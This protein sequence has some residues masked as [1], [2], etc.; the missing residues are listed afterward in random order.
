MRVLFGLI[1]SAALLVACDSTEGSFV[2]Y[3]VVEAIL[4]AGEPLPPVRLSRLGRFRD[5]YDDT[6]AALDGATVDVAL[7]R[8]DGTDEQV[9]RFAPQGVGRYAPPDPAPTVVPGRTYRLRVLVAAASGVGLDTLTARTTVPA[10]VELL[11]PPPAE[12]TYGEGNGPALRIARSST[13]ARRSVYLLASESLAPDEFEPVEIDGERRFR[14]RGLAGRFGL[15]PFL[16]TVL[17]CEGASGALVC[18]VDPGG[19]A[20]GRTPLL[21]EDNYEILPDGSARVSV[22]YVT[23]GFF[24]PQEVTVYSLDDA[25]VAYVETQTLQ[26]A[27]TTISPGEI[28]NVTTNVENGLGV[29]GSLAR[30]VGQTFLREP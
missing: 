25:L 24:G 26:F 23:F 20:T 29:F 17:G 5:V 3:P 4:E 27:P 19:A 13:E 12:V 10:H 28:P 6:T 2:P 18:D 8:A 9:W 22:P 15:V 11:E 16:V 21:N 30:A 14:Q 1:L 7:V